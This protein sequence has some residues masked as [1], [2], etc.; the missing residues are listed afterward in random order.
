M[1]SSRVAG[2]RALLLLAVAA[3][4]AVLHVRALGAPNQ[5]R[6]YFGDTSR[7]GRPF[8]KDPSVLKI[9]DRYLLYYSMA[10][11]TNPAAP[12]G[13]AIGIAESKDL[14]EW[15]KLGEILPEQDCEKNGIVNGKALLL[16]GKVHLFY[17]TYGNG[18]RDALC[19]AFSEDGLKFR[20][21]PGNPI[22]HA[23]GNWNSGRAIDCDAFVHEGKVYLIYAT[24]DPSMKVQML[25]MAAADAGSDFGPSAWKP[26]GD[27]PVLKPELPWEKRCIE[28]PSVL[29]RGD[30]FYLFYGGGYNN[31]PQQIGFATSRDGVSWTR[32]SREPLIPN[33]KAG[34][35]NASETGHP[36][37]FQDTDGRTWLF[38]QGNNDNGK[39]WHLSVCELVWDE[40]GP[41]VKWDS[42]APVD[43][44]QHAAATIHSGSV[45]ILAVVPDL[46][47]L[48]KWNG[49]HGDTAD[50]FWAD[51]D[52]L[53]HFTCD[54]RGF[55]KQERNVCF[56]KLTGTDLL[57]LQGELVNS[58]DEYGKAGATETDGATWKVCG[59]ECIDGVFYTFVV[60]NIY[61]DKSH[62]PLMRQTSFNASLIKSRDH[63]LT[64]TRSAK[65]NYDS[66]MWPGTR[67]GAPCFIHYG[68]D[69]GQVAHDHADE[70]VYALSNNGFWNGGDDF[71]L[72][73]ARRVNLPKLKAADWTYYTGG[74]GLVE[75]SWASDLTRAKPILSQP[76]KLGWTAPVFI[77]A[78]NR[79]L[80]VS[81]YV[82]PTLKKW[83]EPDLV[84]YD[85]YEAPHPWGPW[86][87]VSSFN[88]SFLPKG[89]HFYGPNLCAKFQERVGDDVKVDLYT[90]G[91]PFEDKPTGLYKNW[92]I[93]LTVKTEP[94]PAT[95]LVNDDDPAIHYTGQWQALKRPERGYHQGD[96]HATM[97]AGDSVEFS[98]NGVGIA[99]LSEKFNDLGTVDVFLD[100][101]SRGAINLR[102]DDFPRLVRITVFSEQHLRPGPHT[103]RLVNQTSAW[104]TV[105]AFAVN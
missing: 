26:V 7:T 87:F 59:Q 41:E 71:I 1:A 66:P 69:G 24:R 42:A 67:F 10:P 103:I 79:Y 12:P 68:K 97:T 34:E 57:R 14:Q 92:R 15:R 27:G 16:G 72:A 93:P 61:G 52:N 81:W 45:P 74:D 70:F 53:Y 38:V 28:A 62:D 3:G 84:T 104:F 50:P 33:G 19:H 91:C 8:A 43:S 37:V 101:R 86:T 23:T 78:V 47:C 80:L 99:L 100:G 31:E 32:R 54:G 36:G 2:S 20:R 94:S 4:F 75:S 13:W 85:F 30:V 102:Q 95:V 22:L 105:D 60:R 6:M 35:W 89:Q 73:R 11:S 44:E 65:E 39:T 51:D 88:D 55:G 98:F 90:S 77:A 9:G 63:G 56:N 18:A 17:N 76:A 29:K 49:M 48:Q 83:F 5:P 82:T 25:A 64:W 96:I 46:S 21:N 58:M 40:H